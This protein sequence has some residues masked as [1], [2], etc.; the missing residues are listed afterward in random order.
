MLM[1]II[2]IIQAVQIL[3][4]TYWCGVYMFSPCQGTPATQR[5]VCCK[6]RQQFTLTFTNMANLAWTCQHSVTVLTKPDSQSEWPQLLQHDRRPRLQL[7]N[8]ISCRKCID[9]WMYECLAWYFNAVTDLIYF[10][11]N[12]S[13]PWNLLKSTPASSVKILYSDRISIA[14][15]PCAI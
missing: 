7:L 10:L 15:G 3:A 13:I 4:W 9:G 5:Y 6:V 8:R 11:E 12:Y 2:I 1:I 14:R